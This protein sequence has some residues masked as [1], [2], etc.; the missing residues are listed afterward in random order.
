V[1]PK[2]YV[3]NSFPITTRERGKEFVD[4]GSKIISSIPSFP[5]FASFYLL[6]DVRDSPMRI[7]LPCW[8]QPLSK[9]GWPKPIDVNI[10]ALLKIMLNGYCGLDAYNLWLKN[11]DERVRLKKRVV[12][13]IYFPFMERLFGA[14]II[15]G[16]GYRRV[17][18]P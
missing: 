15:R 18:Y 17:R 9:T 8:E 1:T 6:M 10:Q 11:V 16:R 13:T 14:K 4:W 3:T 12:D 2:R 5:S 7:D